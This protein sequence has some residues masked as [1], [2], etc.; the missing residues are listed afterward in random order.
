MKKKIQNFDLLYAIFK[1]YVNFTFAQFYDKIVVEGKENIPKEKTVILA[2][3]HQNALMDALAVLMTQPGQPVFLARA[4]I[5][6]KKIIAKILIW[7]NILPVYR[8]RDGR[9]ELDKNKEIFEQ[10]IDVLRDHVTLCLMPEGAQSFKRTLLPLVKGMFRIAFSAQ[11]ELKDSEIVI[12][13]VGID[14]EDY[15]KPSK[16]LIIRFGAP[17]SIN[18]YMTQYN[19]HQAKAL[20]ALRDDLSEKIGALIQNIRSEKYY[21]TFYDMSLMADSLLCQCTPNSKKNLL[22]LLKARQEISAALDHEENENPK[23]IEELA[24]HYSDYSSCLKKLRLKDDVF[25]KPKKLPQLLLKSLLLIIGFPLFLAGRVANFIPSFIS[26]KVAQN[27]KED[28]FRSSFHLVLWLLLY[29]I[30]YSIVIV[31]L[32]FVFHSFLIALGI[33]LSAMFLGRMSLFYQVATNNILN[34]WRLRFIQKKNSADFNEM[35]K[36]REYIIN[37]VLF[38]VK[39][40]FH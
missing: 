39:K 9:S 37:T 13:P 19:E 27:L 36:Q 30:Y 31:V 38:M 2:P 4:D 22:T 5:F 16:N 25:E 40:Y 8:Q 24:R 33:A 18:D 26:V 17:I 28:D 14:Y 12:V 3:N 23:K 6:K 11:E 20:N 7:L 21:A 32:S 34:V 35:K 29:L 10:A 15:V 1:P